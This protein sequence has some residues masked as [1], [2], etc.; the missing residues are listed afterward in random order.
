MKLSDRIQ[1]LIDAAPPG[2]FIQIPVDSAREWLGEDAPAMLEA[3]LTTQEV[4]DLLK[5]SP[6]TVRAWIR[7]GRLRAYKFRGKE[8]RVTRAALG[9]FQ[10]G[11]R[12]R[13]M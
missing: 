12:V 2:S 4:A 3:D 5:R 13:Q 6:V 8:Y 10:A 9:E 11:E 7:E 1:L